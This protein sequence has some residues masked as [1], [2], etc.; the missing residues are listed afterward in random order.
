MFKYFQKVHG[1]WK[2]YERKR[3][4]YPCP[5]CI[6]HETIVGSRKANNL[7]RKYSKLKRKAHSLYWKVHKAEYGQLHKIK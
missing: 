6:S 1:K 4:Y 2:P 7:F 3:K 5:G